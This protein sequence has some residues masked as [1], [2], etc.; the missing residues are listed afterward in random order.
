M[1]HLKR[2]PVGTCSQCGGRGDTVEYPG[3]A[4][5]VVDCCEP[6]CMYDHAP[7]PP[8]LCADCLEEGLRVLRA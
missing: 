5:D 8:Q 3:A 6:E 7:D 4:S 2:D 1:T